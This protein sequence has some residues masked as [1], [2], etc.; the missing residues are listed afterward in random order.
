MGTT[1][2][3]TMTTTAG[4]IA[5]DVD[6]TLLRTGHDPS[7]RVVEAI[8]DVRE[9]GHHL[10]LA[11]GRSLAGALVAAVQ[12]RIREGYVVASNGA[13]TAWIAE[14]KCRVLEKRPAPAERALRHVA[15]GI[16]AGRFKAAAEIV[17]VGYRVTSRFPDDELPGAQVP[18]NLDGLW[19]EPTPRIVLRGQDVAERVLSLRALGVTAHAVGRNWVDVT[20]A[21]LSKATALEQIRERLGVHPFR[22][23]AMGDGGNDVEMLEWAAVPVGMGDAAEAVKAVVEARRGEMTGSVFQDGAAHALGHAAAWMTDSARC[24]R[25][26]TPDGRQRCDRPA[27]NRLGAYWRCQA[28][29]DEE[30]RRR[31]RVR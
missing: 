5:C 30:L 12:L 13:V 15:S 25:S 3:D 8:A 7:R 31:S 1:T 4:L 14:G 18:S 26:R 9:A 27:V 24:Q 22:T 10:V 19:K 17:G 16:V 20:G 2:T 11:T 6:H 28:H 21:G 29:A 23:A